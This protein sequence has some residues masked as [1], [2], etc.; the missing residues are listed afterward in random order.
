MGLL[1]SIICAAAFAAAISDLMSNY[2]KQ[3]LI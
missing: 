2:S 1:G 3:N